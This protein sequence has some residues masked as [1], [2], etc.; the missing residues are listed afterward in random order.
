LVVISIVAVIAG[1]VI[2]QFDSVSHD[3][4]LGTAQVVAADLAHARNLAVTNNSSY[5]ITFDRGNNGYTLAHSGTNIA[6]DVLPTSAFHSA[7][8]ST[9]QQIT[10]LASLP[11]GASGIHLAVVESNDPMMVSF[12]TQ[13]FD[14]EFGPLGETKRATRT[15]I[16]LA[17]NAQRGRRFIGIDVD[18]IT[19]LASI[20]TIQTAVPQSLVMEEMNSYASDSA[21]STKTGSKSSYPATAATF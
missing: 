14:V 18:P 13:V 15:T 16:W 10:D 9:T 20:G 7:S 21:D 4:L 12:P 11:I 5:K 19:G 2:T 1:V 3:Q 6:L 8:G 17:A